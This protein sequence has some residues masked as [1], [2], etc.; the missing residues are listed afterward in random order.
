MSL[1]KI[2]KLFLVLGYFSKL[3]S[4][5]DTKTG[6]HQ[7]ARRLLLFN[8]SYLSYISHASPSAVSKLPNKTSTFYDFQGPTIK[9]HDFPG[10]ENE[11]LKVTRPSFFGGVPSYFEALW[12][13]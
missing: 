5:T 12:Y 7:N 6:V 1:S 9:S 10:L 2:F 13:P 4:S 8:Y 11:M 3:N